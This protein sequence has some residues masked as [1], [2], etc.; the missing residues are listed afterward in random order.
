MKFFLRHKFT[1]LAVGSDALLGGV[2][3][4]VLFSHIFSSPP[5]N[6][7][8][9]SD[10]RENIKTV[11]VLDISPDKIPADE[12]VYWDSEVSPGGRY[13][14]DSYIDGGPEADRYDQ[15]FVTRLSDGRKA[16][17]YHGDAHTSGWSW[18]SEGKLRISYDCGTS[19]STFI[20][21]PIGSDIFTARFRPVT[22]DNP[23]WK[24]RS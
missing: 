3:L 17:V 8:P 11:S 7:Q 5:V 4:V 20:T 13:R 16:L 14:A 18:V 12:P 6:L 23:G 10:D 24:P 1:K 21:I 2:L 19:C 9:V 22:K 15:L